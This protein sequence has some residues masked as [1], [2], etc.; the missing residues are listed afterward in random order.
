MIEPATGAP[1]PAQSPAPGG[2]REGESL[3]ERTRRAVQ[4]EL[5][6]AA[7]E[8]FAQR[9]YEAVTVDEIAEAVGIS[10]RSFFRYFGSKEALV[11]GKY[12]RQGE[13]FAALL[14]DRPAGEAPWAALR[15]MFDG[16]V[17][18]ISDPDLAVRAAELDRVIQASETLR[19]GYLERMERSQRLIVA[20]L[21][22]RERERGAAGAATGHEA[23]D[24]TDASRALGYAAVVAAA[25]AAMS[26]ARG[27]AQEAGLP[28]GEALDVAL[29][30]VAANRADDTA[31]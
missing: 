7:Q 10:R 20:E 25:F 2:P 5:I 14:A 31:V 16:V 27:L 29:G 17:A 8:L 4:S 18:Y 15:R 19:A 24:A 21:V 6:D 30:A 12:D 22:R 28:L 13:S 9:G 11:L 26:A 23:A 1:S 3:R